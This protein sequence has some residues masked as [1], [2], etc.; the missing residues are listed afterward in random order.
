MMTTQRSLKMVK[1]I[2]KGQE[3][4]HSEVDDQAQGMW[5]SDVPGS[6]DDDIES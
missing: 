1:C 2:Q 5:L 3:A 4:P 6:E